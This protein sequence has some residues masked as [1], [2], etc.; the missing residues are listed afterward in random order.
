V[1]P[2][3]EIEFSNWKPDRPRVV[4]Y[5]AKWEEA[6][7]DCAATPRVFGLEETAPEL[8]AALGRLACSSWRLFGLR[9]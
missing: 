5:A 2:I 8:A 7:P 3:A 1:L 4:G 9:G 6:S